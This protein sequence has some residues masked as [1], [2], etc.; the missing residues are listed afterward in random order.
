M[1]LGLFAGSLCQFNNTCYKVTCL[2]GGGCQLVPSLS[3]FT[4]NCQNGYSGIYCQIP[5]NPN[6]ICTAGYC[7]NNGTCFNQTT[8]PNLQITAMCICTLAFTGSTCGISVFSCNPNPCQNGG[9]CIAIVGGYSCFCAGVETWLGF[10]YHVFF[11][12]H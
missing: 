9:A 3:T 6:P 10:K 7:L 12:F 2:N 11:N 5:P 8:N 4:C 1:L